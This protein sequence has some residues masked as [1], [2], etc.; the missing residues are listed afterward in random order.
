MDPR[1]GK[2]REVAQLAGPRMPA[3]HGLSSLGLLMQLGGS[4][5]L[6][7]MVMFSVSALFASEAR[8]WF[9]LL[10]VCAAGAVR[11]GLHRAA[12]TALLYGSQRGPFRPTCTYVAFAVAH[13]AFTLLV[14]NRG[15]GVPLAVNLATALLLLGWP[16]TLAVLLS[17]PR[18]RG[19]AADGALPVAEDMGF[20]GAA[21]LMVL[22]GLVG[23]LAALLIAY[24]LVK[25][26][27]ELLGSPQG[28]LVVGVFGMLFVRSLLHTVAGVRGTR[29]IDSDG[30]IESTSRYY[31]FG[32]VS[33]VI[34]GGAAF[35][36]VIP[37]AMHPTS[38]LTVGLVVYVLLCWPLI[39]RRYYTERVFAN[40]LAGADAPSHRRAP[41]AGM[42]AVGWLLLA[43]GV[44]ML[45]VALPASLFLGDAWNTLPPDGFPHGSLLLLVAGSH[46][47]WWWV[48]VGMAQVWA[49]LE[50]VHMTD[51]HRLAPTIYGVIATAVTLYVMWPEL[52]QMQTLGVQGPTGFGSLT[53]IVMIAIILVPP[54]G[55]LVLANRALLPT[56]QARLRTPAARPGA[57]SGARPGA[58]PG[59]GGAAGQ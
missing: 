42:T 53:T 43:L 4:L 9:F 7:G 47:T 52:G 14:L 25:S 46:S 49:G 12:G 15:G 13:S 6:G 21:A 54:I 2:E 37:E 10:V 16:I 20:E 11:S 48:G 18:L 50:L 30:A 28:L 1:E 58:G 44:P 45:A 35:I 31:S 32:V 17:R 36:L 27:A 19:L 51:R 34:A 59:T 38:L 22:L 55:T 33:S 26:P 40:L 41:D 8:G 29:G 3:D 23:S 24:T 5:F 56:A 39:L 57:G